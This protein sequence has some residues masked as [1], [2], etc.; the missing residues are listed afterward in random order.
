MND[1]LTGSNT[2]LS[3]AFHNL[4]N[5]LGQATVNE[6]LDRGLF[7]SNLE[8]V[9]ALLGARRDA[10][11]AALERHLAPDGGES[12]SRPAG[13]YFV[14]LDLA[15]DVDAADVLERAEAEGVTF[16]KGSDFFPGG[17]GG[18]SAV[19]LAFSFETP[20]RIAEGV[21]ILGSLLSQ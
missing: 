21:A 13:G 10:M 4:L 16:V 8:R 3:N 19:R 2:N 15:D 14:W 11:L 20:E 9:R 18:Q 17:A 1:Y 6:F 7:E 12:W 5:K